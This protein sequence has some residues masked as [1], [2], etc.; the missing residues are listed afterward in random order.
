LSNSALCKRASSATL[1]LE[2]TA[3]LSPSN[4]KLLRSYPSISSIIA[5]RFAVPPTVDVLLLLE[6]VPLVDGDRQETLVAP[7]IAPEASKRQRDGE[8]LEA[9]YGACLRCGYCPGMLVVCPALSWQ[10]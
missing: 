3:S 8:E 9:F 7:P 4:N 6:L 10:K 1:A 5:L 2:P